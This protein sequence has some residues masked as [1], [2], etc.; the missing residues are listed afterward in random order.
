MAPTAPA[1]AYPRGLHAV[2]R[3]R[4]VRAPRSFDRPGKPPMATSRI[5]VKMAAPSA[6]RDDH[7]ALTEWVNVIAFTERTRHLLMQCEKGMLVAICGNVTKEFY[8]NRSSDQREISR[9]IIVEDILSVG[10]SLQPGVAHPADM[11][12]EM[13]TRLTDLVPES[14]PLPE[15]GFPDLD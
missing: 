15:D 7:D 11:D 1:N 3:G 4:V 14:E 5:A 8:T 6:P 13:K 2:Y 12:H 10:G 9:T